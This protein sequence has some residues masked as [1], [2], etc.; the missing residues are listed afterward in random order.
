M[1]LGVYLRLGRLQERITIQ[2][3]KL[4]SIKK[5]VKLMMQ[6]APPS[7]FFQRPD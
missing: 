2:Q 5:H 1:N 4:Q 6:Y 7:K 3:Q